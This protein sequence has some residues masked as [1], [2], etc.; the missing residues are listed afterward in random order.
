MV[1]RSIRF[2]VALVAAWIALGAVE[3]VPAREP[4]ARHQAASAFRF[5][6]RGP[7]S[8]RRTSS[9]LVSLVAR[10]CSR[11]RRGAQPLS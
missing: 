5:A 6:P 11:A 2:A 8:G 10:T 7:V 9:R 3:P 4:A 1:V